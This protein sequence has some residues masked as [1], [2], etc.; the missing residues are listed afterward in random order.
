M[1]LVPYK[2][3][4]YYQAYIV[5]WV[6]GSEC[7][8]ELNVKH[9]KHVIINTLQALNTYLK[10]LKK[11]IKAAGLQL[12][13]YISLKNSNNRA[14]DN[15]CRQTSNTIRKARLSCIN[16]GLPPLQCFSLKKKMKKHKAPG[17]SGLVA[18]MIQATGDIG[19]QW[20]LDL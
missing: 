20:I 15:C 7:I 11:N 6:T 13:S 4:Y 16:I 19:T 17:L 3:Y 14:R 12:N 10:N 8:Q 18:E 2:I 5:F 1:M 9:Q